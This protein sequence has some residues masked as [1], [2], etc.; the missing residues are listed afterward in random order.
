M[1]AVTCF[2]PEGADGLH[3]ETVRMYGWRRGLHKMMAGAA[4]KWQTKKRYCGKRR[5]E[6]R[7]YFCLIPGIRLLKRL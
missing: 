3:M 5:Y 6:K 4:I 2:S 7:Y 1:P